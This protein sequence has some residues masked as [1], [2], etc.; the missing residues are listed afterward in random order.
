[1]G[2]IWQGGGLD[3]DSF[4]CKRNESYHEKSEGKTVKL[5]CSDKVIKLNQ[6]VQPI[7]NLTS[8]KFDENRIINFICTI[9]NGHQNTRSAKNI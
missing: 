8:T 3:D 2:G 9:F 7:S 6:K 4:T 1:M 5:K